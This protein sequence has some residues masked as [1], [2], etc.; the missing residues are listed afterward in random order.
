MTLPKRLVDFDLFTEM[1]Y[2]DYLQL[3][4]LSLIDFY[5][6][7]GLLLERYQYENLRLIHRDTADYRMFYAKVLDTVLDVAPSLCQHLCKTDG[8][9]L[10]V[11]PASGVLVD[12]LQ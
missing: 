2:N 10:D 12:G 11:A 3:F 9:P 7:F 1:V 4:N 6:S 5:D 8:R